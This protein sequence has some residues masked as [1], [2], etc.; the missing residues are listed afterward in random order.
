MCRGGRHGPLAEPQLLALQALQEQQ[1]QQEAE[2]LPLA[3]QGT[4]QEALQV[5]RV[6]EEP[7]NPRG[8]AVPLAV[9]HRGG[10]SAPGE[11]TRLAPG[12]HRHLRPD[13]EQEERTGREAEEGG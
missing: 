6:Q 11:G 9:Q 3:G 8:V 1:A 10:R 5:P 2:P 4:G 13:T 12:A 7:T